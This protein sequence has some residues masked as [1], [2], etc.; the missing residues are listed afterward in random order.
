MDPTRATGCLSPSSVLLF[1]VIRPPPAQSMSPPTHS[2]SVPLSLSHGSS[3]TPSVQHDIMSC[4]HHLL[5]VD[6]LR[7][8]GLQGTG[9]ALLEIDLPLHQ[10]LL[11][12]QDY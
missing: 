8:H 6:T 9:C 7:S 4:A 5:D 3:L 1:L 2:G 10:E 11:S 12:A